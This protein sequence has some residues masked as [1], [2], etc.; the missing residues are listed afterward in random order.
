MKD[1]NLLYISM[2]RKEQALGLAYLLFQMLLLPSILLSA[3]ELLV[4]DCSEA[5]F[6]FIFYCINFAAVSWIFR[7]FWADCLRDLH[8][9]IRGIFWKAVLGVIVS[10]LLVVLMNDLFSFFYPRFYLATTTGPKFCNPNDAAIAAMVQQHY[11][12]M[13]IGT[14]LLVPPAEEILYRGLIF[15]GLYPKSPTMAYVVSVCLFAAIHMIGFIGSYSPEY[16]IISFLQY[17][18]AG[19]FLAWMYTSSESIFTP[20][21]MHMAIN[22]IGIYSMR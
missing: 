2:T 3:M 20:I 19:I 18:P 13:L 12:L 11:A 21:V 22:A 1:V 16:L 17:I 9:R 6:N 8:G 7:H 15:G 5:V 14:V 4:P 10:Q